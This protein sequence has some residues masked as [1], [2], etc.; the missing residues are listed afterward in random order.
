MAGNKNINA[1][2]I[3]SETAT[4]MK[5]GGLGVVATELPEAFNATYAANGDKITV[6]TPLYE[7]DTGRKK[8]SLNKRCFCHLLQK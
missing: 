7:G 8:A 4:F 1:W 5:L 3:S 2:M 6:V